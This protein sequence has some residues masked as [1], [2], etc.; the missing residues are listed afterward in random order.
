M[1]ES[2][3]SIITYMLFIFIG[4]FVGC[5]IDELY[6]NILDIIKNKNHQE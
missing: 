3:E 2:L 1:E 6:N 5:G 4:A